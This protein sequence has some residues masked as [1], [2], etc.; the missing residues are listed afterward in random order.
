M[1]FEMIFLIIVSFFIYD[2]YN[3]NKYIRLIMRYSKYYKIIGVVIVSISVYYFVKINP[4]KFRDFL[5]H[6]NQFIKYAP[7]DRNITTG[8]K[9]ISELYN[10]YPQNGTHISPL[11]NDGGGGGGSNQNNSMID[12]NATKRSVSGIKK[13][14]IAA[15]QE[16]K[17]GKCG[18]LLNAWYEVDHKVRLENGG[19]NDVGNL[20]ALCRECHG[21]KTV[22]ECI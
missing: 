17:C 6:F 13:K 19:S 22:M 15:Q 20:I 11:P 7:V 12:K 8:L 2:T 10:K 18:T 21:H 5:L 4:M 16:W 3:D 9:N 14:Y 1:S